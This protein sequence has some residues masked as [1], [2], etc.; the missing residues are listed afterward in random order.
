MYQACSC[1]ISFAYAISSSWDALLLL[2]KM[3]YFIQPNITFNIESIDK[4]NNEIFYIGF[5]KLSFQNSIYILHLQNI[6]TQLKFQ[7]LS[8][9]SHI[10]SVQ[11]PH[12][13]RGY[14]I[15]HDSFREPWTDSPCHGHHL[16]KDDSITIKKL[17]ILVSVSEE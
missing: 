7:F 1:F 3:S 9:I 6:L 2:F 8:H 11:Q 5:F 16:N 15:G 10:S 12:V 14:H 13:G 4:K 17:A